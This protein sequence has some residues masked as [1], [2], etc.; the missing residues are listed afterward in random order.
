MAKASLT[1]PDGTTV[2]I[3]GNPEEINKIIAL[4]RPPEPAQGKVGRKKTRVKKI[5]TSGGPKGEIDLPDLVN[6]AKSSD[7]YELIET[8]ILDRSSLV[9]RILLPLYIANKHVSEHSSMTSGDISK[10]LS[11][12]GVN[13][14]QPNVAKTLSSTALKYVIGDKIRKKGQAVRYRL[15]RRGNQYINAVIKGKPND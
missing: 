8:N 11:Q 15:S 4:H 3:E 13:I 2:L 7:D 10:F 6:I 1:L 9:D 5:P 12:F 14:A